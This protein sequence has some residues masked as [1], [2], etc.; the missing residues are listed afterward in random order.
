MDRSL[1]YRVPIRDED[2][3]EWAVGDRITI[4]GDI[5]TGRDAVLPKIC[6]LIQQGE[7]DKHVDLKGGVVFHT[8]VSVAGIGPTSSNKLEIEE[9][10][11]LLSKAGVKIHLGKGK[12]SDKTVQI[13]KETG[14][15][16][17]VIPPVTALLEDKIEK[18]EVVLFEEEGME[19]FGRLRMKPFS[20]IIAA[21]NGESI[22]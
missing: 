14:A 10:F 6:K 2:I 12:I 5:F 4:S 20:I 3:V 9:S 11:E 15:I 16:Y 18:Q 21:A 7:I 13:L 19:A 17:A 8:A 1:A 22:Y